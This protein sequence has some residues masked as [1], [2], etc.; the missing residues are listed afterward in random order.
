MKILIITEQQPTAENNGGDIRTMNFVRYFSTIGEV[1]L[2][3][4]NSSNVIKK[5]PCRNIVALPQR[6]ATYTSILLQLLKNPLSFPAF[7]R[8]QYSDEMRIYLRELICREKYD[9]VFVRY[10]D[11]VAYL[12]SLPGFIK[13]RTLIDLDNLLL[14]NLYKYYKIVTKYKIKKLIDDY[15]LKN[16][17][18]ICCEEFGQLILCSEEDRVRYLGR[19]ASI[20]DKKVSIVPNVIQVKS[21]VTTRDEIAINPI[22]L[23]VGT[24]EY[25]VNLEGLIW[26]INNMYSVYKEKYPS[27]QLWIVGRN[28]TN[29]PKLDAILETDRTIKLYQNVDDL[30]P[31][32]MQAS[33]VIVPLL[34][35][36]G[37]R[38][39][40]LEAA[41][42]NR[43]V[44]S[45]LIG[46]E[47]IGLTNGESV[48][49]FENKDD[50]RNVLSQL[51]DRTN[52]SAIVQ[53]ASRYISENYSLSKF[54]SSINDIVSRYHTSV[55]PTSV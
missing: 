52:Y 23:F 2:Y 22:M 11:S 53:N 28:R 35:G 19:H 27:G 12:R 31:Y 4:R 43:P 26:F 32:Y 1:D 9:L 41:L 50:F 36:S 24:L 40:I 17:E 44:I 8:K 47:G 21:Q 5:N 45:T 48:M 25:R 38:I 37:T 14:G 51:S 54:N 39:K 16:Y 10:G 34:S 46:A 13:K 33:F 15:Q 30:A 6:K 55:W 49:I 3:Y 29:K 20:K 42:Y 18:K 7:I